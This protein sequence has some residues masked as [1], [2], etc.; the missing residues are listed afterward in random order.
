MNNNDLYKSQLD[1][2]LSEEIKSVRKREQSSFD[3]MVVSEDN[4]IILC[5]AGGLGRK[6]LSGLRQIGREPILLTDNNK[7]LWGSNIEGIPVVSPEEAAE[8]YGQKAIFLIT[9]WNGQIPDTMNQ[10]CKQYIDLQCKYVVPFAYLFWKY[11]ETFLPHYAFD[12]AHKVI[13][14]TSD[15]KKA[16][17]L[18]ADDDSKKEYLAQIRWRLL[19]DFDCLPAPV[20]H[21][22]YFPDDLVDI[23]D[24]EVYVDCGAFD[25][26]TLSS[27]L[28]RQSNKFGRYIAYEPDPINLEKL[29][30]FTEGLSDDTRNKI[31]I[32]NNAVGSRKEKLFFNVTGTGAS[33]VGTGTLEVNCEKMDDQIMD[34]KPTFIKM[35]IEG[36][37]PDA[38]L[39]AKQIIQQYKPV[40]A[41]CVYHAQNHLWSIPLFIYSLSKDYSF[42]LRPHLYKVWDLVCYAIPNERLKK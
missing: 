16:F 13:E 27:F 35:D 11:P 1:I 15:I 42:Y 34:L 22:I 36:V 3:E 39:G 24:D 8:K 2:L 38:L 32:F 20:K 21:E 10:C 40:L 31:Q 19:L 30:A 6:T 41:I 9:I 23:L 28:K 25:G 18:F 4:M 12:L 37:E 29:T 14:Q 7:L 33:S 5:G 26:D 17:S